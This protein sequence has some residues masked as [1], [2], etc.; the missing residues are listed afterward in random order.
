MKNILATILLTFLC[1]TTGLAQSTT[2]PARTVNQN[3]PIEAEV[4]GTYEALT[5]GFSP[6]TRVEANASK[7][8]SDKKVLFGS[9][10]RTRRFSLSDTEL[11]AGT[12]I[13][14]KEKW[15][16]QFEGGGSPT[17]RILPQYTML[18]GL[19]RE[20][21]RGFVANGAYRFTRYNPAKINMGLFTVE[22]YISRYRAGYTLYVS[23]LVDGGT[24]VS[25]ATSY[26]YYYKDRSSITLGLSEGKELENI[27]AA[28]VLETTT[29]GLTLGGRHE[30]TRKWSVSYD[31]NYNKQQNIY[32]RKGARLGVRYR[33]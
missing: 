15:L 32:I 1:Q 31:L 17:H 8:F 16:L 23:H 11:V 30:V 12:Y 28:G 21:G 29:R 7:K 26:S 13:P 25:H 4:S 2:P 6:W 19:G 20:L 22:K 27:G 33:F 10:A 3:S 24:S 9:I 5:N 14:V 18:T